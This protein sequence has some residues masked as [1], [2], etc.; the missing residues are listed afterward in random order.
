MLLKGEV[1]VMRVDNVQFVLDPSSM[2]PPTATGM[3]SMT[4]YRLYFQPKESFS[5]VRPLTR[6][7]DPI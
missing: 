2:Y 1:P 6:V 3:L 5:E 7:L 4:T